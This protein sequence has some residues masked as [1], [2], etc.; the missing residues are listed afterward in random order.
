MRAKRLNQEGHLRINPKYGLWP[1]ACSLRRVALQFVACSLW[2][3]VCGL[4]LAAC[5]L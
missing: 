2:L 4:R 1:A 3:A 5:G